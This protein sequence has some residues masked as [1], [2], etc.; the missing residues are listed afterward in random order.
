MSILDK[1][2]NK[3]T[4]RF[5]IY[6]VF[7]NEAVYVLKGNSPFRMIGYLMNYFKDDGNPTVGWKV[8]FGS[9]ATKRNF[10]I[11]NEHFTQNCENVTDLF[12]SDLDEVDE[13]WKYIKGPELEFL[14][15]KT[16]EKI[17]VEI[18]KIDFTKNI[19]KKEED[20]FSVLD[21]IYGINK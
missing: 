15:I 12:V 9:A 13:R 4:T 18:K 8:Y 10:E 6:F 2:F 19:E 1:F 17:N 16:N 3:L 21:R 20:I 5:R 7:E 14:N 11:R